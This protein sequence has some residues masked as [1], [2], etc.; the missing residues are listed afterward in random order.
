MAAPAAA[1]RWNNQKQF[2][3]IRISDAYFR[4]AWTLQWQWTWGL[5]TDAFYSVAVCVC[6]RSDRVKSTQKL[7]SSSTRGSSLHR[8]SAFTTGKA[9]RSVN[10]RITLNPLPHGDANRHTIFKRKK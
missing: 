4:Y 8:G 2:F 5:L 7:T 10:E 6:D 1:F 3:I 9:A